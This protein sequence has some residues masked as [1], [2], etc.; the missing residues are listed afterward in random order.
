MTLEEMEKDVDLGIHYEH[1][2]PKFERQM[3]VDPL[4]VER[5]IDKYEPAFNLDRIRAK[6]EQG[7]ADR[8]IK[9]KYKPEPVTQ[10][11]LKD[12][13]V[14]LSGQQLQKITAG[15]QR[16]NF[17]NVFVK[18]QSTKSFII[19]ND[20]R[21]NI[22]VRLMVDAYPELRMSTPLSQVIPPGQ[23]AGFDIIFCS[24][25]ITQFSAPITYY[26]NDRPFNFLVTAQ[27]EPASLELSKK[28]MKFNFS[29]DSMDMFV[30][31]TLNLT[32]FGNATA[33][34]NW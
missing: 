23:E 1:K 29:D 10:A 3:S 21:Q 31:Q 12:C 32:N 16:I 19:T 34:F 24:Q 14:E 5:P 15:P 17:K 6:R 30:T 8:T 4:Y 11:E 27:A 20:L 9:R 26:I 7:N 22:Y 25:T 28:N 33:K 13:S 18:S 2:H